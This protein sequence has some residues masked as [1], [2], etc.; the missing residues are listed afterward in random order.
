MFKFA[1]NNIIIQKSIFDS[2]HFYDS[3]QA[4]KL[5]ELLS[6]PLRPHKRYSS[7]AARTAI[8]KPYF[9]TRKL[10]ALRLCSSINLNLRVRLRGCIGYFSNYLLTIVC[11]VF[12]MLIRVILDSFRVS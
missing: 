3:K 10:K 8:Y 1:L 7:Y 12:D 4:I 2:N 6:L 5:K 9:R 11:L